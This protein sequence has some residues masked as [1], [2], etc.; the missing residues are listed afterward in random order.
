MCWTSGLADAQKQ[1][2]ELTEALRLTKSSKEDALATA[3]ATIEAL[4][5]QLREAVEVLKVARQRLQDISS[6]N[7]DY[8]DEPMAATS[9][10]AHGGLDIIAAA[11]ARI[12][13]EP[14]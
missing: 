8:G 3:T 10:H 6:G 5:E 4:R 2:T 13:G 1:I 7:L 14:T 12:K 11:L 9:L